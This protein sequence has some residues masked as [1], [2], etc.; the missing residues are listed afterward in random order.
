MHFHFDLILIPE[1]YE[2]IRY[3]KKNEEIKK[4]PRDRQFSFLYNKNISQ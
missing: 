3:E 2:L 1:R 4:M